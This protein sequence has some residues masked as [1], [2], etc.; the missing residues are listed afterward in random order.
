MI[1]IIPVRK[2][3]EKEAIL[4]PVIDKPLPDAVWVV[5]PQAPL[6]ALC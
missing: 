6:S 5:A 4:P 2:T 1:K 3:P